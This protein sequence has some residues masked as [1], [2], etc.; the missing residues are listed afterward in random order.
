M[1]VAKAELERR[2]AVAFLKAMGLPEDLTP[3]PAGSGPDFTAALATGIVGLEVTRLY[4]DDVEAG[5][6]YREAEGRWD[7]VLVGADKQWSRAGLPAVT[8]YVRALPG[9]APEKAT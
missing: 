7:Q 3:L 8:V 6:A 1:L 2:L 4:R 5:V 9:V